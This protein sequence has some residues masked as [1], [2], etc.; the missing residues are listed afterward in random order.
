[1]GNG[2]AKANGDNWQATPIPRWFWRLNAC[3]VPIIGAW[4]AWVTVT[5]VAI[6]TR[7]EDL[8]ADRERVAIVERALTSHLADPSCSAAAIAT[9][10]RTVYGLERRVELLE[11]P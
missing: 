1:M 6:K 11:R 8:P 4:C 7:V 2:Q 10:E 5:L 9:V 3:A